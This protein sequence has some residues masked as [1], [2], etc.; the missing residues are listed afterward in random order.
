MSSWKLASVLCGIAGFSFIALDGPSKMMGMFPHIPETI[1]VILLSGTPFQ[2]TVAI[3]SLVLVSL[4]LMPMSDQQFSRGEFLQ[5]IS[6]GCAIVVSACLAMAIHFS[7]GT[8]PILPGIVTSV[9]ILQGAL[10]ICAAIILILNRE[11]RPMASLPLIANSG[12]IAITILF[13]IGPS[14]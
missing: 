5:A 14:A 8:G 4:G 7:S 13:V 1:S 10:G 3:I 11:T 2:T 12:L 6:L 9:A